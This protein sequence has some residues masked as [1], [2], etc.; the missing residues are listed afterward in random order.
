[1]KET[2]PVSLGRP[3]PPPHGKVGDKDLEENVLLWLGQAKHLKQLIIKI[4][5][6]MG[7]VS[8]V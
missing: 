3:H 7:S 2:P 5:W 1:M 4:K 8:G 6:E